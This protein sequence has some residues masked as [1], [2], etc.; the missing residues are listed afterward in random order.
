MNVCALHSIL[1][2][3]DGRRHRYGFAAG[4]RGALEAAAVRTIL[5][6]MDDDSDFVPEFQ[7]VLC[8]AAPSQIVRAHT[9][10]TA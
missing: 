3:L 8:P 1:R 6:W 10:D 4:E 9:L 2:F 7:R 5:Q